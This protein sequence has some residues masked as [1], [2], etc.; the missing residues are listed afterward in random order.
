MKESKK[1][2]IPL[3]WEFILVVSILM[4]SDWES[5]LANLLGNF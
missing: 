4:N 1:K 3:F 2:K 5:I